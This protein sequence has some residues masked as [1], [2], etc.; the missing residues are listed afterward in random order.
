MHPELGAVLQQM[1]VETCVEPPPKFPR[2]PA[3]PSVM[4]SC[5]SSRG[6]RCGFNL[7]AA[8]NSS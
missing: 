6:M 7:A 3:A 1:Q 8:C 2:A 4:C 5:N